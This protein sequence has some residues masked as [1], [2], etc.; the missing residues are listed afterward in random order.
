MFKHKTAA[1]H[2][3]WPAA[4]ASTDTGDPIPS[5]FKHSGSQEANPSHHPSRSIPSLCGGSRYARRPQA[6][7]QAD[8]AGPGH[9]R[10]LSHGPILAAL[11]G[12]A[13]SVQASSTEH[14][15]A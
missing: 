12:Q 9:R 13:L 15:E 14:A 3:S 1:S 7:N 11:P 6:P 8:S 4:Q 2:R 5:R 10:P